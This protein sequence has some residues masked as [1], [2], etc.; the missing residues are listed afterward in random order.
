MS[1][2]SK[3][4]VVT[5]VAAVATLI[6][7]QAIPYGRN[8]TNPPV[9]REPS[10]DSPATRAL[11]KR[12]CFNCHSNETVWPWYSHIAPASWL[13]QS[14]VDEGRS[15]L[16][17]SDWHNGARKAENPDK[18][19]SEISE[20]G[21]PPIQYRLVHPEAR[22]TDAEKRQLIDGIKATFLRH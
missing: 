13:V 14:D 16:N 7:I 19:G 10:W 11:A 8:H 9:V 17:F 18:I 20:G 21:M 22:L 15:H 3:K 12:A 5:A 1:A 6:L 2:K 4:I